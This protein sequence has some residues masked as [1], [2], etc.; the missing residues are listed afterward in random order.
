MKASNLFWGFFFITFGALY[1]VARYS[2][3]IIDWYEIWELWPILIILTGIAIILKSS[4]FKPLISV[5]I[6]ILLAFLAFGFINDIF[7]VVDHNHYNRRWNNDYSEN[8]YN[9][10]YNDSLKHVNLKIEAGAGKFNIERT[11]DNLIKGYSKGNVGEYNFTSSQDDSISWINLE[12]DDIDHDI[13]GTSFQNSL[14]L[15]LNENPTYNFDLKIGAAKSYFNL[16][17]FKVKNLVLKTGATNTKIKLG[18]QCDMVYVDIEMGAASLDIFVPKET[19]CKIVGDMVLMSKDLDG[20]IKSNT[21]FY[22]TDNYHE[23][24]NKIVMKIKGGV[25]A[26]EVKRY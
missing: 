3:F 26:L 25:S 14:R 16:I 10:G 2:T 20:F 22:L 18:D 12:M 23:S 11:T 8:Y 4:V 19:G 21:D 17:P 7:N 13:F 5:L 1:L 9:L 24:E 15:S 6:G